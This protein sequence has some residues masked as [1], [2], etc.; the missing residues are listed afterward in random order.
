[1]LVC[2]SAKAATRG[3][4]PL[5]GV[6]CRAYRCP[7]SSAVR[8]EEFNRPRSRRLHTSTEKMLMQILDLCGLV[9]TSPARRIRPVHRLF[10]PFVSINHALL[11]LVGGFCATCGSLANRSTAGEYLF[12]TTT[13]DW[14]QAANWTLAGSGTQAIPGAA[15]SAMV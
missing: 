14:N 11:V 1:M 3:Q 12:N 2:D 9:S 8:A 7:F 15:D 6:A 13:G 10:S 4:L 5:A